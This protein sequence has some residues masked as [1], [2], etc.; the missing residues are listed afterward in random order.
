MIV[1]WILQTQELSSFNN[2][3]LS[4]IC[5]FWSPPMPIL[6]FQVFRH[7]DFE[8]MSSYRPSTITAIKEAKIATRQ[9]QAIS[10][11]SWMFKI[12]DTQN[13]PIWRYPE[14]YSNVFNQSAH[15]A[16]FSCYHRYL[17]PNNISSIC[18][19]F[20]LSRPVNESQDHS[21]TP[22]QNIKVRISIRKIGLY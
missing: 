7:F 21:W 20:S 19:L 13:M 10:A 15:S 18:S 6:G 12:K 8:Q 9:K 17:C 22:N 3:L 14:N 2:I 4:H 16:F 11:I 5:S 1:L